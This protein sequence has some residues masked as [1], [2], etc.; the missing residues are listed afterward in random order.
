MLDKPNER[1]RQKLPRERA[2]ELSRKKRAKR[3]A[4]ASRRF[5]R[6]LE[7]GF[8]LLEEGGDL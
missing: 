6:R 1:P 4:N 5:A 2:L 3:R 7:E 8:R